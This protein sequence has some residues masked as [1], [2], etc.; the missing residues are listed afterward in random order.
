MMVGE[1][2]RAE[3]RRQHLSQQALADLLHCDRSLISLVENEKYRPTHEFLAEVDSVLHLDWTPRELTADTMIEIGSLRQARDLARQGRWAESQLL[4]ENIWWDV[5]EAPVERADPVFELWLDT[6]S[7]HP[8]SNH[9]LSMISTYLIHK[10]A[11][12][13]WERLFPIGVRI[14]AVL[15]SINAVMIAESVTQS[16]LALSPP[17]NV[18]CLLHIGLGTVSLR[19]DRMEDAQYYYGKALTEWSPSV[20]TIHLGRCYHGLG[21]TAIMRQQWETAQ[22]ATQQA[23]HC[24]DQQDDGLY[25]AALQNLGFVYAQTEQLR[26]AAQIFQ[27]CHEYWTTHLDSD[28]LASLHHTMAES[29]MLTLS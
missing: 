18:T 26:P 16:L 12:H 28:R 4:A 13:D 25:Y 20:G 24:Y 5:L 29:G 9:S 15:L 11:V 14:Q 17:D 22:R 6:L 3:R 27:Q 1:L 7:K 8:Q 19:S 23:L 10:T 2:I 21:A